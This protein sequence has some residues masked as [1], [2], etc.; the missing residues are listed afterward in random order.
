MVSPHPSRTALKIARFM[1]MLDAQPR[2]AAV[3]P[4]EAASTI[5]SILLASRAIGPA[6]VRM[7]RHP[8]V[9]RF[10]RITEALTGRGQLLWF[11][12]RK[13]WIADTV[14]AAIAGGAT[15]L[16]VVGAGFDP[17][18]A[19]VARRYPHMTCVEL[20]MPATAEPKRAG[21][22]GAGLLRA[23]LHAL[24]ADL[25][26][27]PIDAVLPA[28]WRPDARSVF[29]AEGL[30]MYLDVAAV[31]VFFADVRRLAAPGSRLAFTCADADEQG[32]PRLLLPL[33]R[34][35]R[36]ALRLAG[37][38]I[39]WGIRPTAL[40]P[41]LADQGMRCLDQPDLTELRRRYL[42]PLGLPNEP[43]QPADYLV[44]AELGLD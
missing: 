15:Q 27:Q 13:R 23:N 17:L 6:L 31:Q 22:A 18:A 39:R 34:L 30:L 29:V 19:L 5:E 20:D 28:A 36:L 2:L 40:P 12:V 24:S 37:E 33:D 11:G 4:D 3:L 42:N 32:N 14:E 38:P 26:R 7:M 16:L 44:L 21:L 35:A 10:A 1:L 41:F 43:L 8:G 9:L 25:S